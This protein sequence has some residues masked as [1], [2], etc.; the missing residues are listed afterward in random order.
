MNSIWVARAAGGR[1]RV[2]GRAKK[3]PKPVGP[4][5]LSLATSIRRRCACFGGD[6]LYADARWRREQKGCGDQDE[7]QAGLP[8]TSPTDVTRALRRPQWR[9]GG[10][11]GRPRQT[12]DDD[13]RP[14]DFDQPR[15]DLL[16]R[17]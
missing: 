9:L 4:A 1:G 14:R 7:F 8:R 2:P 12:L 16:G 6:R 13:R 15:A 17:A 3:P 5:W 11:Y 10:D